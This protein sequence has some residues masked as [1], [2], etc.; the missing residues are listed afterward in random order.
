M[1]LLSISI[2]KQAFYWIPMGSK[3]ARRLTMQR[4]QQQSMNFWV[5]ACIS[6]GFVEQRSV[7]SW[8]RAGPGQSSEADQA[9]LWGK[10]PKCL[11]GIVE[12]P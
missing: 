2:H 9:R 1:S 8:G 5:C 11:L 7:P 10:Q 4:I 3:D 12:A 6:M